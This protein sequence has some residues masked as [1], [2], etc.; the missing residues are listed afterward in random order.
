MLTPQSGGYEQENLSTYGESVSLPAPATGAATPGGSVSISVRQPASGS[1]VS[2][3]VPPAMPSSLGARTS[4]VEKTGTGVPSNMIVPERTVRPPV[5]VGPSSP[6]IVR[7]QSPFFPGTVTDSPWWR[8]NP[9]APKSG[10]ATPIA[11]KAFYGSPEQKSSTSRPATSTCQ[12]QQGST[13]AASS[14]ASPSASSVGVRGG[15]VGALQGR[16]GTSEQPRLQQG[17]SLISSRSSNTGDEQRFDDGTESSVFSFRGGPPATAAVSVAASPGETSFRPTLGPETR[18]QVFQLGKEP[19]KGI[20]GGEAMTSPPASG[21]T[22]SPAGSA[23][24]QT[25][26]DQLPRNWNATELNKCFE[27]AALFVAHLEFPADTFISATNKSK[28]NSS[29]VHVV[30]QIY[31]DEQDQ[32]ASSSSFASGTGGGGSGAFTARLNPSVGPGGPRTPGATASGDHDAP[33][34]S[35][36]SATVVSRDSRSDQQQNVQAQRGQW[37]SELNNRSQTSSRSQQ[38]SI[39]SSPA[40]TAGSS[41]SVPTSARSSGG[42]YLFDRGHSSSRDLRR[43]AQPLLDYEGGGNSSQGTSGNSSQE[44]R[45]GGTVSTA[46]G[47][48]TMFSG[49]SGLTSSWS[50]SSSTRSGARASAATS[51]SGRTRSH[52][53]RH[54]VPRL[55]ET[56]T[57]QRDGPSGTVSTAEETVGTSAGRRDQQP[58]GQAIQMNNSRSSA[59]REP[60]TQ[61]PSSTSTVIDPQREHPLLAH[62]PSFGTLPPGTVSALFVEEQQQRL[63]DQLARE[64]IEADRISAEKI[65]KEQELRNA[66][67]VM[68]EHGLVSSD[69]EWREGDPIEGILDGPS[70]SGALASSNSTRGTG[71]NSTGRRRTNIPSTSGTPNSSTSAADTGRTTG[72]SDSGKHKKTALLVID[73]QKDF[74]TANKNIRDAFPD[75]PI[76]IGTLLGKARRGFLAQLLDLIVHVRAVYGQDHGSKWCP[77]FTEIN[78]GK[79]KCEGVSDDPEEFALSRDEIHQLMHSTKDPTLANSVVRRRRNS[80]CN[81][82]RDTGISTSSGTTGVVTTFGATVVTPKGTSSTCSTLSSSGLSL[83]PTVEPCS[84]QAS[85]S[86]L[87]GP[88]VSSSSLGDPSAGSSERL[89][90]SY[91]TSTA[92]LEISSD[93]ITTPGRNY[94]WDNYMQEN[95]PASP[96]SALRNRGRIRNPFD[97]LNSLYNLDEADEDAGYGEQEESPNAAVLRNQDQDGRD[98]QTGARTNGTSSSSKPQQRLLLQEQTEDN[99]IQRRVQGDVKGIPSAPAEIIL[100]KPNFD[101]FLDTA[102]DGI[103]KRH[104]IEQ[105]VIAGMVTSAC[106]QASALGAFMRGYRVMLLEDCLA[107]RS[108][109]RHNAILDIYRDYVYETSELADVEQRLSSGAE[110]G[111]CNRE[112]ELLLAGA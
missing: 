11:S 13:T 35:V 54:P 52:A 61:Q 83:V 79:K 36:D 60:S 94:C 101:A 66:V 90:A 34:T 17:T 2:I 99:I 46:T 109:E 74:W 22:R 24:A 107:D 102:L 55:P 39:A 57:P 29:A 43:E 65:R 37:S 5:G 56:G 87:G 10:S 68:Q 19:G 30:D 100:H 31:T 93:R 7:E 72:N 67:R 50:P 98:A 89:L 51:A 105:V 91:G 4:G 63:T 58:Q 103:L 14:G 104:G 97:S 64:R 81:S 108:V 77:F 73:V 23:A 92:T 28:P 1:S 21:S 95:G 27:E 53:Y 71:G 69:W 9:T 78:E 6:S 45:S 112:H 26:T 84:P 47:G 44:R 86:S 85:S 33:G 18:A 25:V 111:K 40:S 3:P 88:Q 62:E 80:D 70:L 48:G 96:S 106:V 110:I 76:K 8:A 38:E 16:S 49:R 15:V 20:F 41:V 82:N 75:F 42:S 12:E 32:E 59:T